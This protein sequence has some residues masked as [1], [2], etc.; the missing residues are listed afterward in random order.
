MRRGRVGDGPRER[1]GRRRAA[2]WVERFPETRPGTY[3]RGVRRGGQLRGVVGNA[4][5]TLQTLIAHH[6]T[7]I[8]PPPGYAICNER[9]IMHELA[10]C[11]PCPAAVTL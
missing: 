6:V 2:A 7:I 5:T 4:H 3:F 1:V 8:D 10:P 9:L 11:A